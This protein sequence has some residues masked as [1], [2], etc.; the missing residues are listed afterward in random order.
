[1]FNI[2]DIKLIKQTIHNA[3]NHTLPLIQKFIE[4]NS[5]SV[6]LTTDMWTARNRQGFLGITCFFF[7]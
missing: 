2:P 3:Y 1:M 5:I 4:N 6:S 7:G